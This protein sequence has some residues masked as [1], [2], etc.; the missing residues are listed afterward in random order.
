MA[1]GSSPVLSGQG[2]K[3][4]KFFKIIVKRGPG[5]VHQWTREMGRLSQKDEFIVWLGIIQMPDTPAEQTQL[6]IRITPLKNLK[7]MNLT[8]K[9]SLRVENRGLSLLVL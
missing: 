4:W 8:V 3:I 7:A 1:F 5:E 2:R 6:I 9:K